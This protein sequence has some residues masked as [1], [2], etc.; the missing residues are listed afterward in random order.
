MSIKN[1]F[2]KENPG[3]VKILFYNIGDIDLEYEL[4]QFLNEFN[5]VVYYC[6]TEWKLPNKF[7]YEK[8]VFAI[9]IDDDIQ[10]IYDKLPFNID[11]KVLPA[12]INSCIDFLTGQGSWKDCNLQK[13][14][15]LESSTCFRQQMVPVEGSFKEVITRTDDILISISDI[16]AITQMLSEE[17][18]FYEIVKK[19]PEYS[20]LSDLILALQI[21][22]YDCNEL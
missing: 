1:N 15:N 3:F 22:R 6:R 14:L 13:I 11:M 10:H 17:M 21:T 4:L 8:F 20:Q 7:E 9:F 19:R 16:I 18:T 12:D 5:S 2:F